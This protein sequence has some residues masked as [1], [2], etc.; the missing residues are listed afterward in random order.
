MDDKNR[1]DER[2]PKDPRKREPAAEYITTIQEERE[3]QRKRKAD[4]D[5]TFT[6]R[7]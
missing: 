2:P 1:K 4:A 5:L 6:G 3:D 7:R